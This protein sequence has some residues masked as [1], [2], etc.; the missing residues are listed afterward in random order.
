[1]AQL[2]PTQV[3]LALKISKNTLYFMKTSSKKTKTTSMIFSPPGT[4]KAFI[5][6][7]SMK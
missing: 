5:F 3:R 6:Q 7:R 4:V 1:M 2:M